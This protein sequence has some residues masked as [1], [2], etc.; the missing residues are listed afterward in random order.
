M[1]KTAWVEAV[2]RFAQT[3]IG[4]YQRTPQEGCTGHGESKVGPAKAE[5]NAACLREGPEL[6]GACVAVDLDHRDG[7]SGPIGQC[8]HAH[9]A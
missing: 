9:E 2:V 1:E 6:N 5:G 8:F 4:G 3:A 7:S